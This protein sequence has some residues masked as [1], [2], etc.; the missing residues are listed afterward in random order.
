MGSWLQFKNSSLGATLSDPNN[1]WLIIAK[2]S[3][4]LFEVSAKIGSAA[5]WENWRKDPKNYRFPLKIARKRP[6]FLSLFQSPNNFLLP[7]LFL[8][9][10]SFRISEKCARRISIF[11]WIILVH[12]NSFWRIHQPRYRYSQRICFIQFRAI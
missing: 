6:F 2:I 8:P 7:Q 3:A 12:F 11:L 9:N 1:P 5:N 10:G 4:V